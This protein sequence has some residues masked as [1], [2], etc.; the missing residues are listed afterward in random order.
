MSEPKTGWKCKYARWEGLSEVTGS[1][2][3]H[4]PNRSALGLNSDY[5]GIYCNPS[6]CGTAYTEDPT[7]NATTDY[8]AL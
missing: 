2:I 3:C 8:E 4:H 6:I 7:D 1:L 5:D